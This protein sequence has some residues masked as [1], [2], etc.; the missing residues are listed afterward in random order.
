MATTDYKEFL[1]DFANEVLELTKDA[2]LYVPG[3]VYNTGYRSALYTVL[4]L[5]EGQ[6]IAWDLRSEDVGLRGFSPDRWRIEGIEYCKRLKG[7]GGN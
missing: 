5:L 1:A 2:S 4:N 6:A 7:D 3:D